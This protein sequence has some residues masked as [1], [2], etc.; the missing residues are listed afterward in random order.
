ML[1]GFLFRREPVPA[2]LAAFKKVACL[3]VPERRR[4]I[5]N[6]KVENDRGRVA[7][8][9]GPLVF[10]VE[11]ADVAGG[12]IDDLILP[13]DA[14]LSSEFRSD[15][16]GGVQVVTGE[17]RRGVER[18]KLTAIPYYAWANR[19]KGEMA[20]WLPRTSAAIGDEEPAEQDKSEADGE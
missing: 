16:L 7:L 19:G 9:R 6:E 1:R 12:K 18:V 3:A 20:V 13:D 2:D 8:L 15:L 4:V 5:A 17:A 11:G 10:C 14:A